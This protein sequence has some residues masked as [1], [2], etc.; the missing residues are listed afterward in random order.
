MTIEFASALPVSVGVVSLVEMLVAGD[1]I[2]GAPGVPVSIVKP[3][4]AEAELP[5]VSLAVTVTEC[6]PS[7]NSSAVK[8]ELQATAAPPSTLQLIVPGFTSDTANVMS[9]VLSAS[10]APSAG[11]LIVT[12]GRTVS[13][14]NETAAEPM[15]PA[16]SVCRTSM[17]WAPS[18]SES[19]VKGEP[20][21]E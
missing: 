18:E 9:G 14:T 19:A 3:R 21:A 17:L 1:V 5:A 12:A 11:A 20:H 2:E 7:G 8:G 13:M 4:V 6:G 15:L 10:E 16:R